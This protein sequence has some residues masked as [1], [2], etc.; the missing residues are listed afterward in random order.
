[1]PARWC[2]RVEAQRAPDH[3]PR[4]GLAA[5]RALAAA[6]AEAPSLPGAWDEVTGAVVAPYLDLERRYDAETR[7]GATQGAVLR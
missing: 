2:S 1:M 7:H 4:I 6:L 5:A 3:C